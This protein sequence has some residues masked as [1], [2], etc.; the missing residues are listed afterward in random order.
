MR[1]AQLLNAMANDSEANSEY[2][3]AQGLRMAANLI[4][5]ADLIPRA[6]VVAWLSGQSS[7]VAAHP[8]GADPYQRIS[9]NL[10][11]KTLDAVAQRIKAGNPWEQE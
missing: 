9:L 4:E 1:A 2:G 8:D 5:A 6:D 11:A 7:A 3:E 10:A